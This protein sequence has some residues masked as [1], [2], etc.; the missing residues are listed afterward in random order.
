MLSAVIGFALIW[1]MWPLAA[2]AFAALI[3]ATIVHTFNY[4]RDYYI[5]ADDVVRTEAAARPACRPAMSDLT[6]T[7]SPRSTPAADGPRPLPSG[8][9]ARIPRTARCSGS[10]ST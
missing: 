6:A 7:V 3:V 1:H 10:G 4:K 8:R 5:P 2:A 9:G